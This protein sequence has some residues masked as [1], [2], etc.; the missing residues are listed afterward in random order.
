MKW[1]FFKPIKIFWSTVTEKKQK[2]KSKK[3][4]VGLTEKYQKIEE[5]LNIYDGKLYERN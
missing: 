4:F 5:Y 2:N 3:T 1:L